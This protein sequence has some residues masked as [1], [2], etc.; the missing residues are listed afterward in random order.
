MRYESQK[1][2]DWVQQLYQ[3]Y[4]FEAQD[5]QAVA[6][7]ITYTDLHGIASHGVQRLSMYDRFIQAGKID[8]HAQPEIVFET[9]VSA[10]VDGHLGMGQLIGTFAMNTAIQTAKTSGIGIVTVR[11][12]N[13]Y[14]IAG[15]YAN[16]AADAGLVGFSSTNSNPGL[17]PTNGIQS[18][19]GTN[20]I[21][22]AMPAKPHNFWLDFATTTVPQGKVEVY[23]K[24]EKDF[25]ADWVLADGTRP[26]HDHDAPELAGIRD[27]KAPVG[28]TP[29]GGFSEA[30]GSHKG[31]GLA[32]IVEIFTGLFSGG[33]LSP[34][35]SDGK[36][37]GTS[38]S[39]IAIDPAIFGDTQTMFARFD[40]FLNQLR[41]Q[42]AVAGKQ[43]YVHGD[44]EAA[45]YADRKANGLVIDDKTFAELVKV[46]QRL[47]V[48]VPE[49]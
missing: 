37:A 11:N 45:A 15:Y 35:I 47:H 33:A 39:F 10:V 5:A 44:K 40:D 3:A 13:H 12:S 41:A 27:Q 19:L 25:P 36:H 24:L 1:V 2:H 20:P 38:H 6:K 30:T 29:L 4:G 14:G 7:M 21:A 26:I 34:E 18:F 46:S 32:M 31:Y 17:I 49:F 16:L 43:V 42:P 22:F 48:D 8:L 9:P 28:L 23:R